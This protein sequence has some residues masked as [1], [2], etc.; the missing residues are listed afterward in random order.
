M[1]ILAFY[2]IVIQATGPLSH[3]VSTT[4]VVLYSVFCAVPL[5]YNMVCVCYYNYIVNVLII[6]TVHEEEQLP[7]ISL[8]I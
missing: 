3:A 7:K 6:H 8:R 4:S 5:Y 2:A 1:R